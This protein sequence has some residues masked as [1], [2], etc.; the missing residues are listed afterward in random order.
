MTAIRLRFNPVVVKFVHH[1]QLELGSFALLDPEAQTLLGSI[2]LD[3]QNYGSFVL[4]R[5]LG[6]GF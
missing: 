5:V 6:H 3:V 4:N 2:T 1:Q